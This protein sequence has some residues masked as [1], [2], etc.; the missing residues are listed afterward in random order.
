[1]LPPP[2]SLSRVPGG[3]PREKGFCTCLPVSQHPTPS[4]VLTSNLNSRAELKQYK[5]SHTTSDIKVFPG[6]KY[7]YCLLGFPNCQTLQGPFLSFF[8]LCFISLKWTNGNIFF[9]LACD[10]MLIHFF[11]I[12]YYFPCHVFSLS[13]AYLPTAIIS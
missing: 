10:S 8:P 6:E 9:F 5:E 2:I 1:M 4:S 3:N 7:Q 11:A 12:L 13:E